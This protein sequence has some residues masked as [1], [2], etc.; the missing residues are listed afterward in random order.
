MAGLAPSSLDPFKVVSIKV[1]RA[2]LIDRLVGKFIQTATNEGINIP[3][4]I[5]DLEVPDSVVIQGVDTSSQPGV[6]AMNNI[7]KNSAQLNPLN[8]Q[9]VA[10]AHY[11]E[12]LRNFRQSVKKA[13]VTE[14]NKL[15]AVIADPTKLGQEMQ[16]IDVT[17]FTTIQGV[18]RDIQFGSSC[19]LVLSLLKLREIK[20]D[21]TAR[22]VTDSF[23][24]E[25]ILNLDVRAV[26]R[27]NDVVEI[28]VQYS[29]GKLDR[30]YLGLVSAVNQNEQKG[31]IT[32]ISIVCGGLSKPLLTNRMVVDRAVIDQ[33]EDGETPQNGVSVVAG[34]TFA[35]KTVDQIFTLLMTSQLSLKPVQ[36]EIAGDQKTS[37]LTEQ[38]VILNTRS[39][40]E[41][42]VRELTKSVS[43]NNLALV[44]QE[45]SRKTPNGTVSQL[46]RKRSA[47]GVGFFS[48]D[49]LEALINPLI[50]PAF[51]NAVGAEKPAAHSLLVAR[52]SDVLLDER[53]QQILDALQ[54]LSEHPQ[55]PGTNVNLS[56][57]FDQQTF[58]NSDAFQ[59]LYIPLITLMAVRNRTVDVAQRF[60][61]PNNIVAKFS[62]RRARA[63]DLMIRKAFQ[64]FFSQISTPNSV[65][66]EVR[67]KAKFVVYENELNQVI[68]E[69][70]RYNDF[71]ADPTPNDAIG[72]TVDPRI[73]NVE[74]FIIVNPLSFSVGRQDND[75]FSRVD[76]RG[77]LPFI[78]IL[79][80]GTLTMGQYTDIA[81]IVK[82]G[83]RVD[84][85]IYNP[86]ASFER[87]IAPFL[88]AAVE[89]A[90]KNAMTR[91]ATAIVPA[92][93]SYRM[94]RLYFIARRSLDTI[95]GSS[96]VKGRAEP[97]PI[98]G[99][100][101]YLSQYDTNVPYGDT[102]SHTLG[103]RFVR[104]AKLLSVVRDGKTTFV[105][106]FRILPDIT[107]VIDALESN[108]NQG[109][110]S[111]DV[112]D[113]DVPKD[114][115]TGTAEI[116]TDT[117]SQEDVYVSDIVPVNDR[118]AR[119][120]YLGKNLNGKEFLRTAPPQG[121]DTAFNTTSTR[122]SHHLSLVPNV[123][124]HDRIAV[125]KPDNCSDGLQKELIR[126]L[127]LVD[128]R[129][130]ALNRVVFAETAR[131]SVDEPQP[132]TDLGVSVKQSLF[133]IVYVPTEKTNA[134]YRLAGL[135]GLRM[136]LVKVV[137]PANSIAAQT[138]DKTLFPLG[139]D[140]LPSLLHED[141]SI[142]S[143]SPF[144]IDDPLPHFAV[145]RFSPQNP[146]HTTSFGVTAA[147]LK[148][149]ANIQIVRGFV[150]GVTS[151]QIDPA[152]VTQVISELPNPVDSSTLFLPVVF[153]TPYNSD[154]II[155]NV[156]PGVPLSFF[157]TAHELFSTFRFPG[158]IDVTDPTKASD[159]AMAHK[160]GKGIDVSL[161]PWFAR[162][163][164]VL[165][166]HSPY[167]LNQDYAAF[168]G[169]AP[170]THAQLY[171]GRLLSHIR[172]SM[173][174]VDSPDTISFTPTGRPTGESITFKLE[175]V[176][177]TF[178]S[179]P[180]NSPEDATLAKNAF[181]ALLQAVG[182]E[183]VFD[184]DTDLNTNDKFFYHLET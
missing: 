90:S 107:G 103:F 167:I 38:T 64:L 126:A 158:V 108:V 9:N 166:S 89:L 68:C 161:F 144:R 46:A 69:V 31:Q 63:F 147:Q 37:L 110:Q 176:P 60:D 117:S 34:G 128:I 70:P 178:R 67:T 152:T 84:N 157:D 165:K 26:P 136:T 142:A 149:D 175:E 156:D 119:F 10:D 137:D 151:G 106:N 3:Y 131:I 35:E 54:K 162:T 36:S 183:T 180:K 113:R 143:G 94:G 74:D 170:L 29:T 33:F 115:V 168:A 71:G 43:R 134:F 111:L 145:L 133:K 101:G 148:L 82:Y 76:I 105:A 177:V 16:V 25:Q 66:D 57:Q 98:D 4:D 53:Y 150:S 171:D 20:S 18:T 73:E 159:E 182:L 125:I 85:P 15:S 2:R 118:N 102:I 44:D 122:A 13:F 40:L 79:P 56:F 62:G 164:M 65:L 12:K 153:H 146:S 27:E 81:T 41:A 45:F 141:F 8:W 6:T 127:G 86:N 132:L 154:T 14:L 78:G 109:L 169:G 160:Q 28:I 112:F 47:D 17:P 75:I 32:S 184:V 24:I 97:E 1:F 181:Q 100:V 49:D 121:G 19:T 96:P 114:A 30:L 99:Y 138:M 50:S 93:R 83:T 48:I 139:S 135:N 129:L 11:K 21:L 130:R 22:N 95:M 7:K 172:V 61:G 59:L 91:P 72:S 55:P 42:R 80:T 5:D 104:K 77:Y 58:T 124:P 155:K 140:E 52:L 163:G 92:N 120:L 23:V 87:T 123:S 39:I 173:P 174:V 51:D 116:L 179:F 88:F